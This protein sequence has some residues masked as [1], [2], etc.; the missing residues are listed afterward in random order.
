MGNRS[1]FFLDLDHLSVRLSERKLIAAN[2]DLDR[3]AQR[4]D[5]ADVDLTPL[6]SPMSIM[7]R[8]TAPSPWS[9]TTLTV[10]PI[11]CIAQCFH[12]FMTLLYLICSYVQTFP[13][14]FIP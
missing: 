8:L 3:I 1:P 9:F 6:V 11:F 14:P 13:T 7:R 10:S 4:R 12:C 2:R 5:L